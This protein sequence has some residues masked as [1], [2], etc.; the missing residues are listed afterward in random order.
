MRA[1]SRH[2]TPCLGR[3]PAP[4]CVRLG[5]AGRHHRRRCRRRL[6][7][8]G[9]VRRSAAQSVGQ[10]RTFSSSPH[11]HRPV[12]QCVAPSCF[13]LCVH[14]AN[15]RPRRR[16]AGRAGRGCHAPLRHAPA[17]TIEA[18]E[19]SRAGADAEADRHRQATGDRVPCSARARAV[20]DACPACCALLW[21]CLFVCLSGW[22]VKKGWMGPGVGV[23][24]FRVVVTVSVSA[25]RR[26]QQRPG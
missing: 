23:G 22:G 13:C 5:L 1:A 14:W 11:S 26:L 9:S 18:C 19:S 8:S 6:R 15:L 10:R 12:S 20:A 7:R 4:L 24:V 16:N 2:A 25:L 3:D 17:K 21:A